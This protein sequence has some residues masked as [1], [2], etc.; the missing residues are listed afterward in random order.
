MI[1]VI[2]CRHLQA[3]YDEYASYQS[4]YVVWCGHKRLH[5][6]KTC[7]LWDFKVAGR[8]TLLRNHSPIELIMIA[9]VERKSGVHRFAEGYASA[10]SLRIL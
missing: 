3:D 4:R 7:K 10:F 8:C 6:R 1:A 2:G 5:M 9:G